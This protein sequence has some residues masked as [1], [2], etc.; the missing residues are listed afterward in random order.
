MDVRRQ[1]RLIIKVIILDKLRPGAETAKFIAA[2]TEASDSSSPLIELHHFLPLHTLLVGVYARLFAIT[3]NIASTFHLDSTEVFSGKLESRKS[4]PPDNRQDELLA[5]AKDG[6]VSVDDDIGVSI[7]RIRSP[8]HGSVTALELNPDKLTEAEEL[9]PPSASI[10]SANLVYDKA[11]LDGR[12]ATRSP[13][14][15]II[16]TPRVYDNR[17]DRPKKKRKNAMDDIFGF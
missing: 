2:L 9:D 8:S 3:T 11:K 5:V 1:S 6:L 4:L 7:E 10:E 16:D 15:I 13:A 17:I 12:D 14:E